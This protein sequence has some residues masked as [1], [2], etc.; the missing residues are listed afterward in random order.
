MLIANAAVF[1][2]LLL[3]SVPA[4]EAVVR[5]SLGASKRAIRPGRAATY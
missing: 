5:A 2:V 3:L 1:R 4:I